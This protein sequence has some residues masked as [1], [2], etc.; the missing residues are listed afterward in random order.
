MSTIQLTAQLK[1]LLDRGY[2]IEDIRNLVTAPHE[3]LEQALHE[4]HLQERSRRH[5]R[6]LQGQANFAMQLGQRR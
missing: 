5:A 3:V 2:S 4:H 6:L 1:Q